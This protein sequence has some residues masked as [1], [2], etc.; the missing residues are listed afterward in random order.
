MPHNNFYN[1]IFKLESIFAENFPSIAIE[2]N[3][4]IKIKDLMCTVRYKHPY[5]QFNKMYLIKL[6]TRFRIFNTVSFFNKSLIADKNK[7]NRKLA[8]LKHL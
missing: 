3:V 6:Y 5:E 7:K 1:F 4:G 8:I 2:D